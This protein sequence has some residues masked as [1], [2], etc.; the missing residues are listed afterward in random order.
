MA[1]LRC[2][3]VTPERKVLEETADAVTVP[4]PDGELG[5][6]PLHAPLIGRLGAGELRVRQG[7]KL[8]RF[9]VEGGFVEVLNDVVSVVTTRALTVRE[10]APDV[11]HQQL[12]QVIQTRAAGDEAIAERN[13][14]AARLRA[15]LRIARRGE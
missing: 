9:Y 11:L 13:A 12:E 3:V 4:L 1:G 5:I 15:M 10:L 6:Y 2:I 14:Q 7:E 8:R